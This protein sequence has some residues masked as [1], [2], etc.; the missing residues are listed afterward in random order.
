MY[1]STLQNL[2]TLNLADN[3]VKELMPRLFQN[4]MRLKYLELS[5]NPIDDLKSD[6]FRDVMVRA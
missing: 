6:V 1:K 4:L 2:R 5:G 3:A